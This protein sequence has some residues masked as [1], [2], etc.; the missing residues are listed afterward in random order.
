MFS[1]RRP[2]GQAGRDENFVIGRPVRPG[3]AAQAPVDAHGDQSDRGDRVRACVYDELGRNDL[4]DCMA[5]RSIP[6]WRNCAASVDAGPI[7]TP[8]GRAGGGRRRAVAGA[9]LR[10]PD[11]R[12]SQAR[13]LGQAARVLP[14]AGEGA[15]T[16]SGSSS[17]ASRAKA[18]PYIALFIS[19]P[20]NL[21]KLD[22]YKQLNARLADPRGMTEAEA[23]NAR[24]R[25]QGGHH[26]V[27]RAALERSGGGAD[28]G[29]VRLR[30]PDADRRRSAAHSRQR[31]QHRRAVDQ[32]GRHADDRRLVHEVRRHAEYEAAPDCRGSTRSTPATTTIATASP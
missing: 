6:S 18:G 11:G 8:R 2:R 25:G 5:S 32:S 15:R 29:R 28:G 30:Q 21:A 14:A 26:P 16:R 9:V 17:W 31:D 19:S 20:A 7:H 3:R 4:D 24:R 1:R 10:L 22:H 27:V 13:Q 12:R 23:K